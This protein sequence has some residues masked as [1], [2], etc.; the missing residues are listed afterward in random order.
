MKKITYKY[1][2]FI[3]FLLTCAV[4]QG[5]TLTKQGGWT[6]VSDTEK[7]KVYTKNSLNGGSSRQ[8][9]SVINVPQSPDSL[10]KLMVDYPNATSWRQRTKGMNL[11]KTIDKNNWFV[12]YV[13]DLPWPLPDRVEL[14]KCEVTRTATTGVII[15]AFEAAPTEGQ[16]KE[17]MLEGDYTFVPLDNGLTEVTYRVTINSPVTAPAWLENTLIGDAFVTQMELLRN[18]VA[19]PQYADLH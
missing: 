10:L 16:Q 17:E 18:A 14:L 13:T 9:K 15:Y 4:S 1:L 3:L 5:D 11:V 6:L 19:L 8:I 12:N 2:I 7:V